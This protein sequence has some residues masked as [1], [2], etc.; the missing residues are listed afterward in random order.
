M[1]IQELIKSLT[2]QTLPPPPT[3][4]M[5]APPTYV[6]V[7]VRARGELPRL[8]A[9]YGG[10]DFVDKRITLEEFLANKA[11]APYGQVSYLIADGQ[12]YA[13]KIAISMYFAKQCGIADPEPNDIKTQ[14]KRDSVLFF[15][16]DIIEGTIKAYA[17]R[18]FKKLTEPLEKVKN[19][20]IP[21]KLPY[22]E[23]DLTENGTGFYVGS[24]LTVVDLMAF[25]L[26]EHVVDLMGAAYLDKFP[27]VKANFQQV[28]DL[29]AIKKYVNNRPPHG[30]GFEF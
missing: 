7:K 18:N 13:Q 27:K 6:Y 22:M 24:K 23:R 17:D 11:D 16:E 19:E 25:D 21:Q 4:T 12:K 28:S 29:P 20:L 10:I 1:G 14:L 2:G 30:E 9:A 26:V 5:S 15:L 3:S 8:V